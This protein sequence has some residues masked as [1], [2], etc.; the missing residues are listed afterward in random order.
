MSIYI[1]KKII[2]AAYITGQNAEKCDFA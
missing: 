2:I 1:L